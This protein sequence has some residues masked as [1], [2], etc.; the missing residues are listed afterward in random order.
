MKLFTKIFPAVA[1][2]LIA[3]LPSTAASAVGCGYGACPPSGGQGGP[4]GTIVSTRT[5]GAAPVSFNVSVKGNKLTFSFPAGAFP[6]KVSVSV[7]SPTER[8]TSAGAAQVLTLKLYAFSGSTTKPVTSTKMVQASL[9]AS[10]TLFVVL[11]N[12]TSKTLVPVTTAKGLAHFALSV[13]STYAVLKANGHGTVAAGAKGARVLLVQQLLTKDGFKVKA[14]GVF[15]SATAAALKKFQAKFHLP[16][17][18]SVTTQTT[19]NLLSVN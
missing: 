10:P 16:A 6:S 7:V 5:V 2:G 4:G 19:W 11:I 3:L 18:G 13:G 9:P 8:L 15:D 14:S 1:V 17:T 12:G